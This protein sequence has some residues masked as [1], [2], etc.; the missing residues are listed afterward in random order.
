MGFGANTDGWV[1]LDCEKRIVLPY[2][3]VD[4]GWRCGVGLGAPG[5]LTT[6]AAM[7]EF[8]T[9]E[10][11]LAFLPTESTL[12]SGLF[13]YFGGAPPVGYGPNGYLSFDKDCRLLDILQFR[14]F[15]AVQRNI[16]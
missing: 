9:L 2:L 15:F 11:V 6:F 16:V 1:S 12:G 8:V 13:I 3:G 14:P 5:L 7:L 10:R 4:L